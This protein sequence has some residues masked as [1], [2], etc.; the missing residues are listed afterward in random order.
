[1]AELSPGEQGEAQIDSGRIQRVQTVIQF[2][3]DWISGIQRP[4]DTDQHLR[5]VSVDAPVMRVIG[6]GQCGTRDTAVET[7]VVELTSQ[8]AQTSFYVTQTVPVSQLG[9]GHRK[10]LVP[11]REASRS[12][13]TDVPCHAA[14]EL[15][16]RQKAQQLREDG[17]ALV[18]RSLSPSQHRALR[19]RV[20]QIAASQSPVQPSVMK[21]VPSWA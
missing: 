6:V 19:F 3:T 12:S 13:I 20:V 21:G 7:H 14:T 9:K 15:A 11:A 18:H 5:E 4:C 17:L 10:I 8:R 1:M 2:H 16:I